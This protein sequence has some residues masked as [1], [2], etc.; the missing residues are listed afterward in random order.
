MDKNEKSECDTDE[1]SGYED[2]YHED[3]NSFSEAQKELIDYVNF[4]KLILKP[5]KALSGL[6]DVVFESRVVDAGVIGNEFT[7]YR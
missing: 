6:R 3:G 5:F 2:D 4:A 7:E 1:E